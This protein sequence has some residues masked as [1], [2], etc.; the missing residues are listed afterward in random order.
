MVQDATKPPF[1]TTLPN[2]HQ[3]ARDLK[4]TNDSIFLEQ[5]EAV[6]H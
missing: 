5:C 1:G 4:Y 6:L 2:N 3:V